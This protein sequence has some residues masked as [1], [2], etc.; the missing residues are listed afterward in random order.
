MGVTPFAD[1]A[2]Q[3]GVYMLSV[4]RK[5]HF[6][7]DTVV[8]LDAASTATVRFSLRQRPDYT[9]PVAEQTDSPSSAQ[10]SPP[11]KAP[12]DRRPA[13]ITSVSKTS[14]EPPRHTPAYGA[15]YVTSVPTGARVKLDRTERGRTPLP[16]S[17]I[18]PGTKQLSGTLDGYHPW[19]SSVAVH[20]DTTARV[21]ADLPQKTGRLRVLA[22]PWGNHL[23]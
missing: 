10:T 21:H 4:Q 1:S 7:A 14:A 13:L 5:G 22:R 8:V 23:H 20:A 3:A 6:R 9:G 2:R 11:P 12:V 17:K 15:L 16:V 18:P 19:A